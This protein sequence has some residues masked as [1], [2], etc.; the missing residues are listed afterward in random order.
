MGKFIFLFYSI[1]LTVPK[2]T[3]VLIPRPGIEPTPLQ[4]K[5]RVVDTEQLGNSPCSVLNPPLQAVI[6]C[7]CPQP[8]TVSPC[9]VTL[10]R[11]TRG[12]RHPGH[13]SP[14]GSL[15]SGHRKVRLRGANWASLPFTATARRWPTGQTD[16][17]LIRQ[18]LSWGLNMKVQSPSTNSST[19]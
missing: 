9:A 3:W 17:W 15:I 11:E 5:H 1:S 18:N 14:S 19:V 12:A 7:R 2:A 4:W 10:Q 16:A 6:P 8:V 13:L